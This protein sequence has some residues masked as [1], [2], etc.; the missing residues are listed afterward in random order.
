MPRPL[1][2]LPPE[3][4]TGGVRGSDDGGF[5][6]RVG[7]FPPHMVER[8]VMKTARFRLEGDAVYAGVPAQR[9]ERPLSVHQELETVAAVCALMIAAP[10]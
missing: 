9:I 2:V 1:G 4:P 10:Q 3:S 8:G 6:D 7:E 5:S